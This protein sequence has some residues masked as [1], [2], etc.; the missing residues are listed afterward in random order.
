[1][2]VGHQILAHNLPSVNTLFD[3]HRISVTVSPL[4]KS[5]LDLI[6][7]LGIDE[8]IDVGWFI[9]LYDIFTLY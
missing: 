6:S 8:C 7:I 1:V 3:N 9:L 4:L 2:G 5:R